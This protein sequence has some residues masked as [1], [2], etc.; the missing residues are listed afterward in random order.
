MCTARPCYCPREHRA[1]RRNRIKWM[2]CGLSGKYDSRHDKLEEPRAVGPDNVCQAQGHSEP[3]G[4]QLQKG[5]RVP[6]IAYAEHRLPQG[7]ALRARSSPQACHHV[8]DANAICSGRST[9]RS[10]V[11]LLT[12]FG[13]QLRRGSGTHNWQLIALR[14]CSLMVTAHRSC[15]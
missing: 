7:D 13:A 4:I 6:R 1:R 2:G 8:A 10:A 14:H 3:A 9:S 12:H 11:Q 5:M 15:P